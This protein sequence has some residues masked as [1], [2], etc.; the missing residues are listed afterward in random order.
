MGNANSIDN[1]VGTEI[2]QGV[3]GDPQDELNEGVV[4]ELEEEGSD[5]EKEEKLSESSL[6]DE[7]SSDEEDLGADR[8]GPNEHSN[9]FAAQGEGYSEAL[10]D[11]TDFEQ[12]AKDSITKCDHLFNGD[13]M[14]GGRDIEITCERC[15]ELVQPFH[16]QD[17]LVDVSHNK[18]TDPEYNSGDEQ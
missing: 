8:H 13:C 18:K 12:V 6:Y 4:D 2:E 1:E 14:T 3:K 17:A 9:P 16:N 10:A 5:D 7:L 11:L 15:R